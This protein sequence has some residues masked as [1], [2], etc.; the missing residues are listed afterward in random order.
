[1]ECGGLLM[2]LYATELLMYLCTL[3]ISIASVK[4]ETVHL[5]HPPFPRSTPPLR[6][7]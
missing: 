5:W 2:Y 6:W 1:M 4:E 7:L 3:A